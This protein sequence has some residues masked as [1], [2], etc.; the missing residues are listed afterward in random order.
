MRRPI[1]LAVLFALGGSFQVHGQENAVA[2]AIA[3]LQRG[4]LDSAER[5]LRTELRSRPNDADALTVLGVVLDQEKKLSDADAIYKRALAIAP[6]SPSLLN[7]YGNHLLAQGKLSEAR[8]TYMQALHLN[9]DDVNAC[10]QIARIGLQQKAPAATSCLD[11]LPAPVQNDPDILLLRMQ[12]KYSTGRKKDADQMLERLRASAQTDAKLSFQIGEAL[13]AVRE[14]DKAET[15]FIQSLQLSPESFEALYDLGLAASHAGHKERASDVLKQALDRQPNNVD[16]LYDSAVVDVELGK[17]ETSL[18]LLARAARLAPDRAEVQRLIAYTSADLGDFADALEAWD[19]YLRL[20]PG[21]PVAHRE[22]A[23]ASAAVGERA[24]AGLAELQ[25]YVRAHPN[26]AIGHYELGTAE[27]AVNPNDA[28][29]ELSRALTLKPDLTAAHVTRGLIRYRQGNAAA[30]LPDLEAAAKEDAQNPR[31]LDRL[32]EVYTALSRPADALREFQ[33]A[34]ELAPRDSSILLHLGR[35]LG[36]TGHTEE[37]Q[38]VFARFRELGP[39]KAALPRPSGLVD[40]LSLSPEQQYEKYRAGV[41]RTVEHTPDSAEAQVRYLGILLN[42]RDNDKAAKTAEKILDLK[43]SCD[44]LVQAGDELLAAEQYSMAAAFLKGAV[45][46]GHPCSRLSLDVALAAFH[47]GEPQPG[48]T[49]LEAIPVIER[50]GDYF[51]AKA[52]ILAS[53]N[54]TA[55]ARDALE[56]GLADSPTHAEIYRQIALSLIKQQEYT[57]AERV[58]QLGTR[59]LPSDSELSLLRDLAQ[60]RANKQDVQKSL[61]EFA[62]RWPYSFKVWSQDR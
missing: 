43:P 37:A 33:K 16:V 24:S 27:S 9:P 49:K 31:V 10:K 32:G 56:R 17:K 42:E 13:S 36:S 48:L 44:L 8:A 12:G 2:D 1:T 58:L 30:A 4:D 11:H 51:F 53:L 19:R 54:K 15:F 61:D 26:D 39:N 57:S 6:H 23:F 46:G 45:E 62:T 52:Q 50:N 21:D 3:A 29:Q 59:V 20:V 7:N 14:Y 28:L 25:S 22:S 60:S 35:A 40:F 41:Q 55:E 18:E 34:A 47:S 5:T 38:A